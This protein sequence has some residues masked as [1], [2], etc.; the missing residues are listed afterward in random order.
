MIIEFRFNSKSSGQN[1]PEAIRIAE[2]CGGFIQ[3]KF[4][5]IKFDD[6]ENKDLKKLFELVGNLKGTV[7]VMG[8][9]EPVVAHKFF[10]AV[11]CPEKLLC[12]GTCRH[13]RLGYYDILSF[14]EYYSENI[15]NNVFSTTEQVLITY[16]TDFLEE[17]EEN[18]FKLNKEVFLDYFKRETEMENKFCQKYNINKAQEAIDKLP[19]EIKLNPYE[20]PPEYI[21]KYG[22]E[23][24]EVEDM[25]RTI[26]AHCEISS[27]LTISEIIECSKA[28]TYLITADAITPLENTDI[29]ISSFPESKQIIFAKLNFDEDFEQIDELE[30]EEIKYI[31][32][33]EK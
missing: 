12:K 30:D 7:I 24:L 6:P 4:Y 32:T 17:L 2:R 9:E 19:D 21:E 15:E 3:D 22:E 1:V 14:L 26:L 25:I 23:E 20:E 28:I 13:V 8:D 11:N 27:K 29:L 10:N 31:V 18:R 33:K 5:K 16:L